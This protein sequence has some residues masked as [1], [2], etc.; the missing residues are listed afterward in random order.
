MTKEEIIDKLIELGKT[1]EE[2]AKSLFSHDIKGQI[3]SVCYCPIANYIRNIADYDYVGVTPF[4][5][6]LNDKYDLY[7]SDIVSLFPI[8]QFIYA[9]DKKEFPNLIESDTK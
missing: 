6:N 7:F 9:F 3:K 8:Q 1:K 2:I 4:R 5:I